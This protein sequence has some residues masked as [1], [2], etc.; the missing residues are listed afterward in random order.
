MIYDLNTKGEIIKL[1]IK[2]DEFNNV[3]AFIV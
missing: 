2:A 3:Y 1:N